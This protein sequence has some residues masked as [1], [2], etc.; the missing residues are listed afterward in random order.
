M[1][2]A[3]TFNRDIR[4]VIRSDPR[5]S[6]DREDAAT[7]GSGP[8]PH[9]LSWRQRPRQH[10]HRRRHRAERHLRPQRHRLLVAQLDPV[11]YD[12]VRE[13]QVQFAPFDVEYGQFTRLRDQRRDQGRNEHVPRRRLLRIFEQR[14]CAATRSTAA[15]SRR[16]KSRQALGRFARRSDL[17]GPPVLLRRLRKAEGRQLAGRRSRRRRFAE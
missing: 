3:P 11:P 7:G 9:F 17:Q 8:G 13:T 5:V 6:L 15:T 1:A 12:A 14:P 10:L 16:S 4:D 2:N